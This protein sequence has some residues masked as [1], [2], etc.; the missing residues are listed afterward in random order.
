M[1]N[2]LIFSEF[3][4]IR[5][6]LAQEFAG[7][8]QVVIAT[9][10]PALI[11]ELLRNLDPELM[12]IDFHLNKVNPW[13]MLRDIRKEFPRLFV[14][15][16]TAYSSLDGNIRLAIAHPDGGQNLSLQAFM[17]RID[18]FLGSG[19]PG[20]QSYWARDKMEGAIP[21]R[22]VSSGFPPSRRE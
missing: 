21:D 12:L 13:R 18:S 9:G 4:G 10:N 15:P 19:P 7:D 14:L 1:G 2:I 20:P 22:I 16:Y 11:R 8:R 3:A 6:L 17:Q 5:E